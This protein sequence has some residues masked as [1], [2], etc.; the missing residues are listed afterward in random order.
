LPLDYD[1]EAKGKRS[2]PYPRPNR[3]DL[4]DQAHWPYDLCRRSPPHEGC[5]L[6]LNIGFLPLPVDP[7]SKAMTY[8]LRSTGIKQPLWAKSLLALADGQYVDGREG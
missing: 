1:R 8:P 7:I 5:R 2:S 3:H 6:P 4:F